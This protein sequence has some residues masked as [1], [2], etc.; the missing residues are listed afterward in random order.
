VSRRIPPALVLIAALLTAAPLAALCAVAPEPAAKPPPADKGHID[1]PRLRAEALTFL[2]LPVERQEQL[3]KLDSDL[4]ALPPATQTHLFVVARRYADWLQGLP[5]NERQNLSELRDPQPR[6]QRL[7]E[8]RQQ[9][10]TRRL[11]RAQRDKVTQAKG[12]ERGKL[13]LQYRR[14]HQMRHRQWKMAFQHWD[15]LINKKPM[16]SRLADFPADVQTYVNDILL[17]MLTAEEKTRLEKAE[18]KWPMY[19]YALV[20][21]ADKHPMALPG[22]NGP[23]SFKALPVD[24]QNHL[25]KKVGKPGFA[26]LK[27]AEGKWPDYAQVVCELSR[28]RSFKLPYELWPSRR[29]DLSREVGD[30]LDK[31]LSPALSSSDKARLKASEGKWPF[32]PLTLRDLAQQHQLRVPWQTLPGDPKRWDSYRLRTARLPAPTLFDSE[33]TP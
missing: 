1:P 27:K 3:L 30:F 21:L 2:H 23:T 32:Y 26:A 29:E 22:V 14:G 18:G 8:L 19:P 5:E 20:A 24:V 11:P 33:V 28:R 13:L 9:E 6:L 12:E 15:E 31:K 17:P 16:P 25:A 7:R 4:H 10:W